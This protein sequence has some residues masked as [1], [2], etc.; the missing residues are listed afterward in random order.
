MK[1]CSFSEQV[2]CYQEQWEIYKLDPEYQCTV[3]FGFKF[4]S[5]V[6]VD[7]Q[8]QGPRAPSP[9]GPK[10]PRA[11]TPTPEANTPLPSKRARSRA[12]YAN[13]DDRSSNSE[14]DE[15]EEEVKQMIVDDN[16]HHRTKLPSNVRH[17]REELKKE[18]EKR[19]QKNRGAQEK[20]SQE[21]RPDQQPMSMDAEQFASQSNADT[22]AEE[23]AKR[24]GLFV[25]CVLYSNLTE[26]I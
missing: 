16:T 22:Q 20:Y 2:F 9:P 10:R 21:S 13:G 14:S 12:V 24:K 8:A 4:S 26:V 7:P 25:T 11:R 18:R 23:T 6:K 19:W 1:R 15:D 5:I 3:R 17:G